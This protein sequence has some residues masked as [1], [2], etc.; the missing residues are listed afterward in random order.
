MRVESE[1]TMVVDRSSF[2]DL[3]RVNFNIRWATWAL[4]SWVGHAGACGD[5]GI[6]MH[7]RGASCVAWRGVAAR[8][9]MA[10]QCHTARPARQ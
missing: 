3:L 10:W 2:G 6:D 5:A 7:A 8:H 9:G 1:S 4:A